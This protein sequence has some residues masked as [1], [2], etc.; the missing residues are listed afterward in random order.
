MEEVYTALQQL[1]LSPN[2]QI[3]IQHK[4]Q[5][6][7]SEFARPKPKIA[8]INQAEANSGEALLADISIYF[9][10]IVIYLD[11]WATWCSPCL[12][13]MRNGKT[14]KEYYKNKDVVFVYL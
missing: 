11:I 12:H 10:G 2:E 8:N 4:Y 13:E 14:T 6:T 1:D 5:E 7:L 9:A 3:Y